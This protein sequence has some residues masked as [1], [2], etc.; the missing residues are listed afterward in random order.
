ME[1]GL[2]VGAGCFL[3]AAWREAAVVERRKVFE[4]VALG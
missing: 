4:L 3:S 2:R 1:L